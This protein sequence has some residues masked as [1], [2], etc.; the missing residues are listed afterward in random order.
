MIV[1]PA[2]LTDL[3]ACLEIDHS[4]VTDYVWQMEESGKSG[5]VAVIFRTARLPRSM[6]VKYPKDYDNLLESWRRGE[7][8][9]VAEEGGVVYGYLDMSVQSWHLTAWV[10]NLAVAQAYRRQGIGTALLK[11]AGEWARQRGL[12]KLMLEIQT[13]NYP[14]ICF[15]QKNGFAF[16]GFNDRYYTN[17][18]IALFFARSI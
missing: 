14:A 5:E 13:K 1:R 3:N 4:Y 8:L 16:C 9:L 2:E 18:D 15:C 6:R 11:K 7:C 12:R 17:Q 10:D